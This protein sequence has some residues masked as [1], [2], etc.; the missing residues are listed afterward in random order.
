MLQTCNKCHKDKPITEFNKT[1]DR[2]IIVR[3]SD[4]KECQAEYSALNYALNKERV[5]ENQRYRRQQ[6]KKR[7]NERR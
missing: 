5:L 1:S 7:N 6:Q 3:R 4:C 2:S